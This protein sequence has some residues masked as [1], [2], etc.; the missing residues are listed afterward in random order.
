MVVP[1]EDF[2]VRTLMREVEF[3]GDS[4]GTGEQVRGRAVGSVDMPLR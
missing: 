1:M 2:V 4:R 3:D